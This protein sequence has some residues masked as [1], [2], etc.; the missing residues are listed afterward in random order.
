MSAQFEF[1]GPLKA[2]VNGDEIIEV[3]ATDI[4]EALE[5]LQE[6]YDGLLGRL[7]SD[8][9]TVHRHINIFLNEEDI[10]L[11]DN[12]QTGLSPGDKVTLISAIAGG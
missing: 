4:G 12:L 8:S 5:K 3:D 2:L 1:L 7:L 6:S 11:K 9:G 10:Q